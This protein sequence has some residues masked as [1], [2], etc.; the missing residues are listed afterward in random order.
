[1]DEIKTEQEQPKPARTGTHPEPAVSPALEQ[2]AKL[3]TAVE[4]EP[5]I[6]DSRAGSFHQPLMK[7]TD[8]PYV[9]TLLFALFAWAV[10]HAV[11]RFVAVPLVKLTQTVEEQAD[12]NHLTFEFENITSGVNFEDLII[13]ILGETPNHQFTKPETTI[14]GGGWDGDASLF[15]VGDGIEL[16]IPNFHPG[17]RLELTTVMTGGGTAL[18]Q[19]ESA[20]V[21]TII[22]PVGLRTWLV[23]WE[24][25]IIAL[26]AGSALIFIIAWA[27]RQ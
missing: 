4:A 25:R 12:G 5:E 17:W 18:V 26:F 21:P 23:E 24:L 9:I 1:M 13:R 2:E 20:G 27:R 10:T 6:T 11:D 8:F 19:L 3:P 7:R 16:Q 22:E 15:E 14:I